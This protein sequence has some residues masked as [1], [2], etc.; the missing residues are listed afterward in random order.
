MSALIH[1]LLTTCMLT[2]CAVE[3]H[4]CHND[5]LQ[6][7]QKF[8]SNT[9]QQWLESDGQISYIHYKC[10]NHLTKSHQI[11]HDRSIVLMHG[12][13]TVTR[14]Q[15]QHSHMLPLQSANSLLSECNHLQN[16]KT[17][18]IGPRLTLTVV[19][20]DNVQ[21]KAAECEVLGQAW[22]G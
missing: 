10:W 16:S 14:T 22:Q 17:P 15:P 1:M 7:G 19:T 9:A 4:I 2:P 18:P 5:P 6:D 13:P 8:G 11:W 20:T 3:L 12:P 21:L